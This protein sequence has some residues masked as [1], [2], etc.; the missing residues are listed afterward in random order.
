MEL[1]DYA[2]ANLAICEFMTINL[3]SSTTQVFQD[4]SFNPQ[5]YKGETVQMK[6]GTVNENAR[7]VARGSMQRHVIISGNGLGREC[8]ELK[9]YPELRYIHMAAILLW[10]FTSLK[11]I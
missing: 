6:Q 5:C 11:V 9:Q 1:R 8:R 10:W 3:S 7:G 2:R 4:L